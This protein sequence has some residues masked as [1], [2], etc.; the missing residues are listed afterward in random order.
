MVT[1]RTMN[2]IRSCL[3]YTKPCKLVRLISLYYYKIDLHSS[4]DPSTFQYTHSQHGLMPAPLLEDTPYYEDTKTLFF[5]FGTFLGMCLRWD[6]S[7]NLNLNPLF[8]SYIHEGIPSLCS[9][10]GGGCVSFVL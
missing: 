5:T 4:V 8:L 3:L 6:I 9:I 2:A 10:E 1:R 7:M